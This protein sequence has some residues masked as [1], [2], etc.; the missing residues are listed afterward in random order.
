MQRVFLLVSAQV[1]VLVPGLE[2]L[3]ELPLVTGFRSLALPGSSSLPGLAV[4]SVSAPV[5]L[6]A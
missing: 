5:L 4:R 2:S 3:P 1:P 6:Q